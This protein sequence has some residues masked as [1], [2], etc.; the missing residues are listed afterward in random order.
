MRQV[1]YGLGIDVG[2]TRTA[3]AVHRDGI[4][5]V[6]TL[7]TQS[8]TMP[9][10]VFVPDDG[11]VLIGDAALRRGLA[12]PTRIAREFKRRMG[13]SEPLLIGGAPWSPTA[14]TTRLLDAVLGVVIEREGG[15][16]SRVILTH[17]A[18]W[19]PFKT[20]L[21]AEAARA[22]GLD[23]ASLRCEPE[24][25]ALHYAGQARVPIGALVAVYDL[26]GG[27]FDAAVLRKGV[28]GF[29]TVG[30]PEG[31]ER[32]GGIDVDAAVVGHV[33]RVLGDV[34]DDLDPA[35]PAARTAMARLR[36]ECVEAKEALSAD[37]E[38]TIPVVLPHVVTEV[39][40]TRAE[41]EGMVAPVLGDTIA[42]LRRALASAGVQVAD[43]AAI[44][45]VGGASRMPLVARLVT[46]EL[47]RAVAVD[48]H[49]KHAIALGAALAAG[50]GGLAVAPA[51]ATGQVRE[52]VDVTSTSLADDGPTETAVARTTATPSDDGAEPTR[53]P[54]GA[55]AGPGSGAPEARA[56]APA[57]RRR[58]KVLVVAG[59]VLVMVLALGGAVLL[60]A[61]SGPTDASANAS[62]AGNGAGDT[63]TSVDAESG[64]EG[65]PR[66]AF[67]HIERD[68]VNGVR[69][70]FEIVGTP[71]PDTPGPLHAD[72]FY[73]DQHPES[74]GID[75]WD[76]YARRGG[77]YY[78]GEP[79]AF[80]MPE[81]DGLGEG[82]TQLC[83][84]VADAD[85]RVEDP[86]A[87]TCVEVPER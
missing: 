26:G 25:A 35:D 3:A 47:G 24:A 73:D 61:G 48:A 28:D 15:P 19:G 55:A 23:D 56:A 54:H 34:L 32:F 78:T 83:A 14:L 44:L 40:L 13:D 53:T 79:P 80:V 12:Q 52:E 20:G 67:Q 68:P 39:R 76:R 31:L 6:V 69:V 85:D 41:L 82:I 18:N 45:L 9:S 22:S 57:E 49:P 1:T 21:L 29:E 63:A 65:A 59:A 38:V 81:V 58:S 74:I 70:R 60:G 36:Q 33:R 64:P 84:L 42:A 5:A 27:T 10:A 50:E 51:A 30:R 87:L 11:P 71:P 66:V 7:G 8:A 4:T 17:P 43:L 46:A 72:F 62:A 37:V 2:T 75:T 86:T 16:P 77:L